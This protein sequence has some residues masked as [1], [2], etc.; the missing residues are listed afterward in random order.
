MSLFTPVIGERVVIKP[1]KGLTVLHPITFIAVPEEGQE[2][3][4]ESYWARRLHDGD[5]TME[6]LTPKAKKEG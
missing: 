4:Y 2:F 1:A 6:S 3:E 5:I